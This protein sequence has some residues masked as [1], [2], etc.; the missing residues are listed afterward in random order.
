MKDLTE[1]VESCR[2]VMEGRAVVVDELK[3]KLPSGRI[4]TREV[5]RHRGAAVVLAR[6]TDGLFVLERQYRAAVGETLLETIAGG[7]EPGEKPE[8]AA[9]R[10]L[11]EESGY[12]A[13]SLT[14]LGSYVMCPGTSE[15]RHFIYLAE[16][17]DHPGDQ[18]FDYDENL[19]VVLL[20]AEDIEQKL[21]SGEL[22]DGKTALAWFLYLRH[23]A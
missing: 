13:T 18:Q 2:R 6:R 20:S 10:E 1:T 19:E 7:I 3:V 17:P 8:D 14:F 23:H 15:E 9:R 4:T 21:A 12:E 16:V 11:L 22:H 5:V